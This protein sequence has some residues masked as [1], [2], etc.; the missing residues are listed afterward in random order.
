MR[1]FALAAIDG[2]QRFI[3][4]YKGFSCAHRVLTGEASCSQFAKRVISRLG[5]WAGALVIMRRFGTCATS[6]RIL[7][8]SRFHAEGT[9]PETPAEACPIWSRWGARKMSGCCGCWPG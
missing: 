5:V 6:A 4:P 3:S 7:A 1:F 9:Q 8:D 2:Y